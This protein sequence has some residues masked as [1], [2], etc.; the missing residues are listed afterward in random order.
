[1]PSAVM[2]K[3]EAD[4]RSIRT[5]LNRAGARLSFREHVYQGRPGIMLAGRDVKGRR[6]RIWGDW[7]YM[8]NSI[9]GLTADA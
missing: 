4:A 5:N 6:V 9:I 3:D 8:V 1:M 7:P 2:S